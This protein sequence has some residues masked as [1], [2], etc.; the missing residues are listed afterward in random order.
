MEKP[1]THQ[2]IGSVIGTKFPHAIR[3]IELPGHG[4]VRLTYV[5][6]PDSV[7]RSPVIVENLFPTWTD[8][9]HF[10]LL[11]TALTHVSWSCTVED[12]NIRAAAEES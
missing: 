12:H 1:T 9:V 7:F 6:N 11:W 5:H 4:G 2:P 8:A 3:L 10:I